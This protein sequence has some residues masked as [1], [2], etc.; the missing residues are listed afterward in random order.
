MKEGAEKT[1][2]ITYLVT[3]SLLTWLRD[4]GSEAFF[5]VE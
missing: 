4:L 3:A 1:V 2:E 5:K